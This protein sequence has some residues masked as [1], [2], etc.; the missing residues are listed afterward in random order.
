MQKVAIFGA[1]GFAR[2]L[3]QLLRD[4][5]AAGTPHDCVGFIVDPEYLET[6]TVN[7]LP[8]YDH[9][10]VLAQDKDIRV[11]IG[12]GETPPRY[13]IANEIAQ[14]F[15]DRFAIFRHPRAWVGEHV[16]AKA[17]SVICA[18][19]LVTTDISVG[20]HSH[21]HVGSRIGHDT[22]IGDF[23]TVAPGATVSGRV[24][25]G[26]GTFIGA[27]AVVL[28]DIQIGAWSIIGAGAV[29]TKDVPNDAT[30]VGVPAR[31]ISRRKPGWHLFPRRID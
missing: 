8:V 19:A 22:V 1:R 10:A 28:P 20:T 3:H 30:V 25:I 27:G 7:N 15:G 16:T 21:V 9:R 17:G 6:T 11:V 29:V 26:D 24:K 2:E 4:V 31:V 5:S 23:V 14:E 12:I 18:G 13:R